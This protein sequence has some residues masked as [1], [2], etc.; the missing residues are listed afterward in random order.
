VP[1]AWTPSAGSSDELTWSFRT[2]R[3]ATSV[4]LAFGSD[5]ML[6]AF[7]SSAPDF[8]GLRRDP[9]TGAR[10]DVFSAPPARRLR[11]IDLQAGG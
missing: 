9:Q 6:R 11:T 3:L 8:I 4:R 5:G 2:Q 10:T 7:V 1:P